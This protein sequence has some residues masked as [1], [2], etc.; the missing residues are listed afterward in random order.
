MEFHGG[1]EEI[2]LHGISCGL[3]NLA[4]EDGFIPHGTISQAR[5]ME[6]NEE[7]HGNDNAMV[8]TLQYITSFQ[9]DSQ[10]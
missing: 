7:I 5:T 8:Y 1:K 10:T 9:L 6:P 3:W 4:G 2:P